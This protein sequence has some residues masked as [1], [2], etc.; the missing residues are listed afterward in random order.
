M[1]EIVFQQRI[2]HPNH[3]LIKHEGRR[4]TF[5]DT[6][7]LRKLCQNLRTYSI[8]IREEKNTSIGE[9]MY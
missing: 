5:S 8:K 6:Q 7:E 3:L 9:E 4:A 1:R 2:Q